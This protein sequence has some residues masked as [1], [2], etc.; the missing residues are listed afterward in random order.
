MKAIV[1]AS[2]SSFSCVLRTPFRVKASVRLSASQLRRKSQLAWLVECSYGL[3]SIAC[4]RDV[5]API[6]PC[7]MCR[8]F[9]REFCS[10]EMPILLVP[11][12]HFDTEKADSEKLIL[13]TNLG[14]LL[15]L[16]FG[17][18]DLELPRKPSYVS[19]YACGWRSV[20]VTDPTLPPTPPY[21]AKPVDPGFLY[22]VPSGPVS[23]C[24]HSYHSNIFGP[25]GRQGGSLFTGC[26]SRYNC[27][28]E[29]TAAA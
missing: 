7:G 29:G 11:G 14:E 19:T 25:F 22:I 2:L 26:I 20:N 12:D 1:R 21:V 5:A 17:P 28:T 4:H 24:S 16:S 9:I 27:T 8:Q 18:E 13:V 10:N 23:L 6:A 3:I 15:P